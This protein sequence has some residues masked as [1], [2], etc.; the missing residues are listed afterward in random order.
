MPELPLPKICGLSTSQAGS[1]AGLLSSLPSPPCLWPPRQPAGRRASLPP[2]PF[3]GPSAAPGGTSGREQ[4]PAHG[5]PPQAKRTGGVLRGRDRMA[6]G[7]RG[8]RGPRKCER[9]LAAGDV[10]TRCFRGGTVPAPAEATRS[11][12]SVTCALP[13]PPVQGPWEGLCSPPP[14]S[15]PASVAASRWLCRNPSSQR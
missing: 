13:S 15:G 10:G 2:T 4:K 1:R 7:P 8:G 12:H 11:R 14:A 9:R 6:G 5:P 3:A